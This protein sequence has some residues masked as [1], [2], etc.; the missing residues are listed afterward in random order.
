M[1]MNFLS[2]I[3]V[4]LVAASGLVHVP[5][6]LAGGNVLWSTVWSSHEQAKKLSYSGILTVQSGDHVQSSKLSHF[7]TP[8]G[9]FELMEN[10][11]GQ[12][13]RWIRHNEKI[14]CVLPEKRLI[15]TESRQTSL[16]F[17][18]VFSNTDGL[19]KLEQFYKI[20]ELPAQRVAGRTA[21]VLMLSPK[22]VYRHTYRL[23]VDKSQDFLLRSELIS[24]E[25]KLLEQVGFAE[26]T[27]DPDPA[28]RPALLEPV[29]GWRETN[30]KITS[31]DDDALPYVLPKSLLGFTKTDSFCRI[32]K[33]T[34]NVNQ[35]VF[36]DGLSTVS[37]F[38]QKTNPGQTTPNIPIGQ[39]A[40]MSRSE[41]QGDYR[42]TVL[43]EVPLVTLDY[44]LKSIQWKLQ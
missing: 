42:V 38:V 44:F 20:E 34:S 1:S 26:I 15:V 29:S 16:V 32:K 28:A 9:E 21:R 19:T 10:L 23:Y 17:P 37:V 8:N 39:G 7:V 2:K 11:N 5:T 12:P 13:Y 22:D 18:G 33:N 40:I 27:F 24:R 6:A 30:T 25:G 3:G 14:Q 35:T 43:G 4:F 41:I 36:S 31:L